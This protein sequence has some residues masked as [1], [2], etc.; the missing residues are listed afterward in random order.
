MSFVV[1]LASILAGTLKASVPLL[2]A[3]LGGMFAERSGTADIALEGKMLGSA[4]AGAAVTA[5]TGSILLGVLAALATGMVLGLI[6]GFAAITCK[7]DQV[8][9]GVAIN[10]IAS[11]LTAT[12]AL[13][14]F[15]QGGRTEPLSPDER[16]MPIGMPFQEQIGGIPVIGQFYTIVLGSQDIFFYLMIAA[17]I[18]VGIVMDK[19]DFGLTLRAAGDNPEAVD[20]AGRSVIAVRYIAL[21]ITGMLCAVAG[22][23]ISMAQMSSFLPGI[24]A[25]Q[26]FL[27][28]TALIFGRWRPVPVLGVCLLFGFLSNLEGRLQGQRVPVLGEIPVEWIQALP[29]VITLVLLAAVKGAGAAPKAIGKVFERHR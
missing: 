20:A 7:G 18:I 6:Q 26:G 11:G 22:L 10:F 9:S 14:T 28:L 4:F 8:V 29:F 25:G 27:A 23:C 15:Q 5:L 16:F 19:T 17:V 1:E 13:A 2:F 3:A 24:T 12:I 21:A